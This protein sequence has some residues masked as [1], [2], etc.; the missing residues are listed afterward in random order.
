MFKDAE[1]E[2]YNIKPI[3][4]RQRMSEDTKSKIG[5]GN[6]KA[7][8]EGRGVY[9]HMTADARKKKS[10]AMTGKKHSK[11]TKQK[12]SEAKKGIPKSAEHKKN[13][14][15]ARKGKSPSEETKRKISITK[16]LNTKL[17]DGKSISEWSQELNIHKN[18]VRFRI[19]KWGHPAYK[20]ESQRTFPL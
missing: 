19:K 15:L 3:T 2:G 8:A 5:L 12:M 13:M 10:I 11:T 20:V 18:T 4:K 1:K 7:R 6:K 17:I 14:S 9:D 16:M